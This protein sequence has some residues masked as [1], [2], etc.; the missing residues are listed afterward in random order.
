M[1]VWRQCTDICVLS[2][3]VASCCYHAAIYEI[4]NIPAKNVYSMFITLAYYVNII[5]CFHV[6][7]N[8]QKLKYCN[9]IGNMCVW[10][11]CTHYRFYAVSSTDISISWAQ[12][13]KTRNSGQKCVFYVHWSWSL[14][15]YNCIFQCVIKY[16]HSKTLQFHWKYV[17][18]AFRHGSRFLALLT[19]SGGCWR[20]VGGRRPAGSVSGSCRRSVGARWGLLAACWRP[21]CVL[22]RPFG[23][24]VCMYMCYMCPY[25]ATWMCII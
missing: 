5:A 7:S 12:K 19:A 18:L 6:F 4:C 25:M 20:P 3:F 1:C 21:A 9:F 15:Y 23:V 10:R 14:C 11:Q 16:V 17:C 8:T 13:W 2:Y 24:C 22:W